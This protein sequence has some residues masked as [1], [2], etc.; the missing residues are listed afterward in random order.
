MELAFATRPARLLSLR[1]VLIA[2]ALTC[3]VFGL[4]LAAAAAPLAAGIGLPP[5]LLFY[6]GLVLLPC[7]ALMA[8]AARTLNRHLVR[9]VIAGNLAWVAA[10]LAVPFLFEVTGLGVAFVLGQAFVVAA[11]ACLEWRSGAG[12][13]HI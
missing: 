7:A 5:V 6:A 9:L 3:L 12:R 2:D 4:L 10:S 1:L 8:I 11:L 13:P